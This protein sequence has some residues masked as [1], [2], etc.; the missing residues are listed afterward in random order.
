M[1]PPN[2]YLAVSFT[3]IRVK[4][5]DWALQFIETHKHH[6]I[7]E[8]ESQDIYRFNKALYLFGVGKYAE[9]LDFIP[10]TSPP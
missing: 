8:N 10:A 3:A 5:L 2:T 7:G 1:L 9:C 4:Q 6:I